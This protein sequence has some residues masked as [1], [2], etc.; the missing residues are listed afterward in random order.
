MSNRQVIILWIIALVLC[1][2]LII[3]KTGSKAQAGSLTK[4]QPGQTLLESFNGNDAG[5][6]RIESAEEHVTLHKKDGKWTVAERGDYPANATAIHELLRSLG[7]LKITQSIEAGPSFAP[8]FGM[9]PSAKSTDARGITLGVFTSDNQELATVSFGKNIDS[10][11]ALMGGMPS[12]RFI[13]NHA[14]QTGI[15]KVAEQFPALRADPKRWLNEEFIQISNIRSISVTQPGKPDIAWQVSRPSAKEEF[16]FSNSTDELDPAAASPLASLFSYARFEDVLTHEAAAEKMQNDAQRTVTIDTF[17]DFHYTLML[18][19]T[20]KQSAKQANET[21]ENE[22]Y[23]LRF[24]VTAD[25]DQPRVKAPDEKP[26]DAKLQ[27]DQYAA[28][29]PARAAKLAREKSFEG[30]TY[31]VTQW[32]VDALLKDREALLKKAKP[33]AP[34]GMPQGLPPGVLQPGM[35]PMPP[36]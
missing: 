11:A 17:E 26:E 6:L 31:S 7:E 23:Y 13:R 22:A 15:Y 35:M 12:G 2:A 9:D 4:R 34:Q 33:T 18:T 32:L 24:T 16:K 19:P 36:R 25:L 14:D 8:R 30:R 10:A 29:K 20:K 27:D 28:Q 21:P 5:T 1:G 3:M